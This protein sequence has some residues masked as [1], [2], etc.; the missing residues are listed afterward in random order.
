[1][2]GSRACERLG[3]DFDVLHARSR[4]QNQWARAPEC[5]VFAA[6]AS[7]MISRRENFQEVEC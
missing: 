3:L 5:W 2:Q 7:L 1:M 6:K 4:L